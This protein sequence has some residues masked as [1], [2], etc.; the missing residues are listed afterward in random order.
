MILRHG[1]PAQGAPLVFEGYGFCTILN[2]YL[3]I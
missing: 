3:T 1:A 2:F